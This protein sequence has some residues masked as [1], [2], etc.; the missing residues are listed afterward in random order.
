M[1]KWEWPV[2]HNCKT[3]AA[4]PAAGPVRHTGAVD[5]A[6]VL[7]L[8]PAPDSIEL[9][10]LRAFV[11]VAQELSFSRAAERLYITQPA[12][13]RQ[14]GALER[15]VGCP[16]LRRST[17]RVELTLAGEA[18][19]ARAG[20]LL[21]DLDNAVAAIRSVGGELA[22]QLTRLWA[23][24]VDV[25]NVGDN[26][27]GLRNAVEE[28]HAKFAPPEEVA[29]R[30]ANLGGV[31]AL[32][33]VPPDPVGPPVLFLHGG[34]HVAGSA[35]GYRHIGGAVAA[36]SRRAVV[37]PEFRLAPEHPFPAA[38]D[39]ARCVY[40]AL[41]DEGG[42]VAVI[43]DSSGAGLVM[44][45]LLALRAD[46]EP[47]PGRAVLM[48][49]WVD[50]GGATQ[51]GQP[52]DAPQIVTRAQTTWFAQLYLSGHPADDGLLDPLHADLRGLPP[53]LIQ[54]GTGDNLV[55]EARLLA[56]RCGAAD[57]EVTFELYPVATHDFH[58]F[59]TF[60]PEAADAVQRIGAFLRG[61]AAVATDA[62]GT[63]A[64]G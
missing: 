11:A 23:M 6:V 4:L 58:L 10:H 35:F 38:L 22:E 17:H 34:G 24:F 47:M 3:A 14:V 9:R 59:W 39:D 53:L 44:S 46:G 61:A 18:L 26:L 63:D 20:K 54:A 60:L 8:Q 40:A 55:S 51:I 45:L 52:P 19:L 37:L 48:C 36:V 49:P 2:A 12:L 28:L 33:C 57:V 64:V 16:L 30:P 7:P 21:A 50:L 1:P 31:P 62:V 15:M 25:H 56:Q 27:A 41:R 13:S 5:D 29:I 32:S 43:G 42:D